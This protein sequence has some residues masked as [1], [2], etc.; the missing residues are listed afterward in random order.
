[1]EEALFLTKFATKVTII[2]RKDS[3]RASKIMQER[4]LKHEKIKVIWNSVVKEIL[5]DSK[6]VTGIKLNNVGTNEVFDF[7]CDGV[8]LAIGHIPNTKPF[9]GKLDLDEK[10]YLK[11]DKFMH[12]NLEGIFGAGD[13]QDTRYRQAITAAGSGCQAAMEVE[14]YLSEGEN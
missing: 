10:G 1:M 9:A 5:G 4:V 13:V 7:N 14:K 12:T 2:H 11:V 3:F 8:F 6:K